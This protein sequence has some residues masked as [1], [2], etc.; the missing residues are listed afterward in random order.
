MNEFL[1]R[2]ANAEKALR[3]MQQVESAI[4]SN[5]EEISK[6]RNGF[7][8]EFGGK[9]R[10]L[11]NLRKQIERMA[12]LGDTAESFET[13]LDSVMKLYNTAEQNLLEGTGT[14]AGKEEAPAHFSADDMPKYG[15]DEHRTRI[16]RE[17]RKNRGEKDKNPSGQI[18]EGI[19]GPLIFS[20]LNDEMQDNPQVD[21]DAR[22]ETTPAAADI[23]VEEENVYPAVATDLEEVEPAIPL[24]PV[25]PGETEKEYATLEEFLEQFPGDVLEEIT[26]LALEYLREYYEILMTITGPFGDVRFLN[27]QDLISCEV[28]VGLYA[29]ISWYLEHRDA[30]YE[31]EETAS[32]AVEEMVISEPEEETDSE[33]D[34]D[35][36]L[37]EPEEETDSEQEKDGVLSEPEEE[38]VSETAKNSGAENDPEQ[39]PEAPAEQGEST[40]SAKTDTVE[41]PQDEKPADP[42]KEPEP[43]VQAARVE[44]QTENPSREMPG[45]TASGAWDKVPDRKETGPSPA[46][47]NAADNTKTG[48]DPAAKK[49]TG[50][51]NTDSGSS[52]IRETGSKNPGVQTKE[53]GKTG[54]QE[55]GVSKEAA[56]LNTQERPGLEKLPETAAGTIPPDAAK[57]GGGARSGGSGGGKSGGGGHSGGGGGS[58]LPADTGIDTAL[59]ETAAEGKE[60]AGEYISDLLGTRD[61]SS[62]KIGEW[63]KNAMVGW[64][65]KAADRLSGIGTETAAGMSGLHSSPSL[66]S[67][68]VGRTARSMVYA[69]VIDAGLEMAM[70]GAG[71]VSS[72]FGAGKDDLFE[73]M[74]KTDLL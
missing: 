47:I 45:Q 17:D 15:T 57:A 69:A 19:L 37:S 51:A 4:R 73:E 43:A 16:D 38:T 5:G 56:P 55:T 21:A 48:I 1:I 27:L 64:G 44:P 3:Q 2:F 36:I 58:S 9:A 41:M 63:A 35:E 53:T 74:E 24:G 49:E 10:I 23:Q 13:A 62:V 31:N 72:V 40:D 52:G 50:I 33:Q 32:E 12:N 54:I 65:R 66:K 25:G 20:R 28:W 7:R 26:E 18:A 60:M 39:N 30:L 8:S 6:I 22:T 68:P 70:H 59:P 11:E 61:T 29:L 46:D 71:A 67:S 42:G 34:K 14:A